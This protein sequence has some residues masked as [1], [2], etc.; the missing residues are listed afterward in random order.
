MTTNAAPV[1]SYLRSLFFRV[2]CVT[3]ILPAHIVVWRMRKDN[4]LLQQFLQEHP[5]SQPVKS[6]A[7]RHPRAV[8]FDE[9]I[10]NAVARKM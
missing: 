5:L 3:K 7:V 10:N 6:H 1:A 8:G 9:Q 2:Q 4:F